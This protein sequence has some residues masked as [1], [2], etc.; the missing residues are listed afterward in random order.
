M[1]SVSSI[2]NTSSAA[3]EA[4]ATETSVYL[5]IDSAFVKG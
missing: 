5:W 4:D 1:G 2:L 3:M